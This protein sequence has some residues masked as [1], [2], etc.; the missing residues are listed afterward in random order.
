MYTYLN[1]FHFVE[2]T[3]HFYKHKQPYYKTNKLILVCSDKHLALK[4]HQ[5]NVET[6]LH[7][8]MLA[9]NGMNDR[10]RFSARGGGD[11]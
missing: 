5:G 3:G 2:W 9:L 11:S 10:F 7:A 8:Q 6:K 1:I 4:M